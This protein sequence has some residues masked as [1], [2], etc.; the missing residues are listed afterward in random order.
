MK[1]YMVQIFSKIAIVIVV[2]VV[3]DFARYCF[4]GWQGRA[5]AQG[6]APLRLY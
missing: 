2:V 4:L 6:L 1:F 3:I 5:G